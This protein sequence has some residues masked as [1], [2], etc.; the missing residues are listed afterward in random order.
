[1]NKIVKRTAQCLRH[2]VDHSLQLVMPVI[3]ASV[4]DDLLVD[5]LPAGARSVFGIV[6]GG[7][8]SVICSAA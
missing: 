4:I 3:N 6:Q 5:T 8:R 1:M 2:S 7:N